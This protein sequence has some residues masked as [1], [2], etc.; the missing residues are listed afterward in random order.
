MDCRPLSPGTFE[1]DLGRP[2]SFR[3]TPGQTIR[4]LHGAAMRDYSLA[5]AG[6]ATRLT[7]CIRRVPSGIFSPFLASAPRGTAIPF[8]GPHGYFVFRPSERPAIFVATGTGIAPFASMARSGTAGFTLLHGVRTPED[9]YYQG[10]FRD[11]AAAYV[12]CISGRGAAAGQVQ[13]SFWGRVTEYV[14]GHLPV[15]AYDFYL[16]GNENMVR[17]VTF[18]VDE[19]FPDSRVYTEIFF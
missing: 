9:L 8:T 5:S 18:L 17:E 6:E 15:M 19:R 12:P 10:L 11:K 3:F 1:L 7:L 16:C 13:G 2:P 14:A 4:L